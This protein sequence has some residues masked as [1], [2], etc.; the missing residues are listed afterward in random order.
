[1]KSLN[2]T[3]IAIYD[4]NGHL[5]GNDVGRH[6]TMEFQHSGSRGFGIDTNVKV[7]KSIFDVQGEVKLEKNTCWIFECCGQGKDTI[8]G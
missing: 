3:N 8:W 4:N 6:W 2:L 7:S 5:K 1:M